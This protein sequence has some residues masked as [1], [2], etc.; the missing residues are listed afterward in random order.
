MDTP[1]PPRPPAGID[2]REG[3]SAHTHAHDEETPEEC[4]GDLCPI[5]TPQRQR[6]VPQQHTQVRWDSTASDG[7]QRMP[8]R[9]QE[10]QRQTP[11]RQPSQPAPDPRQHSM[12]PQ[13]QS[14]PQQHRPQPQQQSTTPQQSMPRTT[15]RAQPQQ[16]TPRAPQR[17]K[18]V[19]VEADIPIETLDS[20]LADEISSL[21]R[22]HPVVA[23]L[24]ASPKETRTP[25]QKALPR[26]TLILEFDVDTPSVTT[27][28]KGLKHR[29]NAT[30]SKK[31]I[32]IS[33]G[34]H[35][36]SLDG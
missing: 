5:P 28:E 10:P 8:E 34:G 15:P 22:G 2:G 21:S 11:Q 30:G 24:A 20:I 3:Y 1:P 26:E 23:P 32:T 16:S 33:K 25:L 7:P 9:M 18:E 19:A 13:Q 6:G 31:K 27:V 12:V 29:R 17:E 4:D 35:G 36:R 14:M